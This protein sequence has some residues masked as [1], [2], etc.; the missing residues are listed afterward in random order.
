MDAAAGSPLP[1]PSPPIWVD[2]L[3]N[4]LRRAIRAGGEMPWT[5]EAL[6]EEIIDIDSTTPSAPS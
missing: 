5:P 2:T 6:C 3:K 1:S 4:E